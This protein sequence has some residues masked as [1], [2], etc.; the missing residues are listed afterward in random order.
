M[1]GAFILAA[2]SLLSRALGAVY[3][4]L[5]PMLVGGGEQGAYALGLYNYSYRIYS[6]A[7]VLSTVGLPLAVSRLVSQRLAQGDGAGVRRVFAAARVLLAGLGLVITLGLAAV[8]PLFARAVDPNALY[9]ILAIAPAVFM[10][11][12]MSAYRG[13]FQ[14]MQVMTPYAV[15]QVVEQIIRVATILAAAV[16]LLPWGIPAAMA[17][18]SFGAVTGAAAAFVYL[19]YTIRR[20]RA[21]FDRVLAAGQPAPPTPWGGIMREIMTLAIPISLASLAFPVIS[22]IDLSV[23]VLLQGGGLDAE[24]ATTAYGALSQAEPFLNVPLTLTTG[25]ALSLVPA[26]TEAASQGSAGRVRRGIGA[27]LRIA[28]IITVPAVTGLILLAHDLAA[29]FYDYRAAG[30][31]LQVLAVAALFI[32]LQQ[33]SSGVLQGLGR[34]MV[35]VRHLAWGVA[36]K[37]LLTWFLVPVWGVTGAAAATVVAFTV[38][39]MLNLASVARLAGWTG[40]TAA[41]V[42]K[43]VVASLMM[44]VVVV[45]LRVVLVPILGLFLTTVTV[46]GAGAVAYGVALLLVGGVR[47]SDLELAPGLAR[48]VLPHLRRW[49]LIRD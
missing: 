29:A 14:G 20:H 2:G 49:R 39:A 36:I 5:L 13:L 1:R 11:S 18:A 9:P 40:F 47:A 7:L 30:D 31:P 48:R 24:A 12:V 45:A 28:L 42:A 37:A 34:P 25:F 33:M 27:S 3:R 38:T 35:P 41:N 44:A 23:P 21:E 17:G 32:G 43:P 15:S 6:V 19:W 46:A 26:I 8:A 22:L 16:L 10:V 4:L